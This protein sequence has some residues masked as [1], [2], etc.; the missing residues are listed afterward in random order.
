MNTQHLLALLSMHTYLG[1]AVS[2]ALP[3]THIRTTDMSSVEGSRQACKEQR[4]CVSYPLKGVMIVHEASVHVCRQAKR[5]VDQL[6]MSS[7]GRL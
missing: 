6:C 1:I 5:S 4:L 3:M 7:H 2:K